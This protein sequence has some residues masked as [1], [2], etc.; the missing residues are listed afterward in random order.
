[1][2]EAKFSFPKFSGNNPENVLTEETTMLLL[3]LFPFWEAL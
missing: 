1:M 3:V 2:K